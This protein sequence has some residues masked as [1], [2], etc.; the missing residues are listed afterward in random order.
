M[1]P[2]PHVPVPAIHRRLTRV[3]DRT[4]ISKFISAAGLNVPRYFIQDLQ[5]TFSATNFP[6]EDVDSSCGSVPDASLKNLNTSGS[7]AAKR[8]THDFEGTNAL[9]LAP[10]PSIFPR[11]P[12]APIKYILTVPRS[13][14][15][16]IG[17]PDFEVRDVDGSLWSHISRHLKLLLLRLKFEDSEYR[18][19]LARGSNQML[20]REFR[21]DLY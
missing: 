2:R 20:S 11:R 17:L 19:T 16:G 9:L 14:S 12:A 4:L 6:P 18:E 13:S 3:V 10:T 1:A 21:W 7:H 8:C 15:N 5:P